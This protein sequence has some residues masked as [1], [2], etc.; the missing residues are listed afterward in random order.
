MVMLN[1]MCVTGCF[2]DF[3]YVKVESQNGDLIINWA[4]TP[5]RKVLQIGESLVVHF[6]GMYR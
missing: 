1:L 6:L 2:R 5:S 3:E 4:V